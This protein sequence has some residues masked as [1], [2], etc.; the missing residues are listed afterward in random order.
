MIDEE[1]KK[2]YDEYNLYSKW[3]WTHILF[4]FIFFIIMNKYTKLSLL[5]IVII[6]LV[7]HTAY[8]YK[9][10]YG[11]YITYENNIK[12]IHNARQYLKGKKKSMDNLLGVEPNGEFHLPPQSFTNSIGD[13]LF[14]LAGIVLGYY[15]KAYINN[16]I[17]N[18]LIIFSIIYWLEV[19]VAYIY[20]LELGLLNK[21]FIDKHF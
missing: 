5:Y 3:S 11:T 1:I 10:Y 16:A 4:G 9:D 7:I 6:L 21:T 2:Q 14:F 18:I 13:T 17:I 12:K 8:E 15:S 19:V 20:V